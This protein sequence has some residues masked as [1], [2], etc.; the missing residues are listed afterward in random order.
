MELNALAQLLDRRN[1]EWIAAMVVVVLVKWHIS[2]SR[3]AFPQHLVGAA[4]QMD[5]TIAREQLLGVTDLAIR[6]EFLELLVWKGVLVESENGDQS[7]PI[8]EWSERERCERK[9]RSNRCAQ[10]DK[11]LL[12][13]GVLSGGIPGPPVS[14]G[15][16]KRLLRDLGLTDLAS[17]ATTHLNKLAEAGDIKLLPVR[18]SRRETVFELSDQGS[19]AISDILI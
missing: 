6:Q 18:L 4:E 19:Q 8:P 12:A 2:R 10:Q 15:A 1:L 13:L 7:E 3:F 9:M 11:V 17:D 16:V 5:M 14:S